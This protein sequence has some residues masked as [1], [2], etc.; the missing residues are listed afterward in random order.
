[1]TDTSP[2]AHSG[3]DLA[4]Q[5]LAAYKVGRRPGTGPTAPARRT[6]RRLSDGPAR[7]VVLRVRC[8]FITR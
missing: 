1:M 3:A 6:Q 4:R 8:L 2:T 7:A 5:A